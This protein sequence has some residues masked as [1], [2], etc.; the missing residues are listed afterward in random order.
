MEKVNIKQKF[1]LFD[2]H[3]SPKIIGE[4]N[5]S[6]IK[7]AKLEG[8]F[9]WHRHENEDEMFL[10]VEGILLLKFRDREVRLE[11]GEFLVVPR[12]VEHLPIAEEEVHLLMIEPK[13]TLNTGD[14]KN[15]RTVEQPQYL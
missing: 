14:I 1:E 13:T 2:E 6:H 8:E 12:G 9:V 5:D 10:V 11:A 4:L 7:I 3:W 15:E